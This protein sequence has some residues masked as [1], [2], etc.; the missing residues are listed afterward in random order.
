MI[1]VEGV[2]CDFWYRPPS[3]LQ[4]SDPVWAVGD[5][6]RFIRRFICEHEEIEKSTSWRCW[7]SRNFHWNDN[8]SEM[9]SWNAPRI[10]HVFVAVCYE[11]TAK[12]QQQPWCMQ[13]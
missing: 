6:H 2:W 5:H 8:F 11:K 1:L 4:T 10:K 9:E 7:A 3:L 12:L 13:G